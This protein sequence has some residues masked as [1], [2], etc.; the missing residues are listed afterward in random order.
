MYVNENDEKMT[1]FYVFLKRSVHV[2]IADFWIARYN[3]YNYAYTEQWNYSSN[4]VYYNGTVS[5]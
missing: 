2:K 4:P 5:S 3:I 1:L